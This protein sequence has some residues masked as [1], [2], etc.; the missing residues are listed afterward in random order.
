MGRTTGIQPTKDGGYK[1]DKVYRKK[2]IYQLGFK[3]V[4]EAESYLVRT[5]DQ[6]RIEF[7]HGVRPPRTFDSA[8]ANY[9][10]THQQKPS[11]E[12]DIYHLKAVMPYIGQLPI[13]QIHNGT[14]KPFVDARKAE[15]RKN[16]TINHSLAIVRRI[17]NLAARDW[18]DEKGMTWL[19][20]PPMITLLPLTDQRPPRPIM[21]D[22]QRRLLPHLA[23]HLA[24]MALFILNTGCRDDVVCNLQWEWELPIPALGISV[25]VVPPKH[26]K[27]EAHRKQERVLVLNT[28]AQ[29]VIEQRRGTHPTHVFTYR[30]KPIDGMSNNGWDNAKRK[31]K[32]GDLHVHDLRH[33]VG[34]RLR[35]AKVAES[36][37]TAV[38]WHSNR[39]ITGHYSMAQV[40]EIF[41]ALELIKDESNRWNISLETLKREKGLSK[42]TQKSRVVDLEKQTG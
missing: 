13:D 34:L 24:A 5:L 16:K 18:R 15:G 7:V 19:I 42:V 33:T 20:T 35:E 37:I 28:V 8:A 39:S 12:S 10:Q 38:L 40:V 9:L 3:T 6:M 21:W 32:I 41:E 17:L 36:T 25:F 11:L 23:D 31:A 26:V 2:R 4:E 30:G 14:L 29:K 22:E 27:G 1:V